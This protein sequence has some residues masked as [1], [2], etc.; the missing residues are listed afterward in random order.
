MS[1][2]ILNLIQR[3]KRSQTAAMAPLLLVCRSLM[4]EEKNKNHEKKQTKNFKAAVS[5]TL[6]AQAKLD[7]SL[8]MKQLSN[9]CSVSKL[10]KISMKRNLHSLAI[11]GGFI[12]QKDKK[13][14]VSNSRSG[15]GRKRC[16][17]NI[18]SQ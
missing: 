18:R 14:K 5:L 8:I 2:L 7:A 9:S 4:K 6:N 3:A 11:R 1:N 15:S 17:I 10:N 12:L 16:L 13:L